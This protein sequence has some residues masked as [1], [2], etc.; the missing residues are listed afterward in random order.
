[1]GEIEMTAALLPAGHSI[2]G[3]RHG[4]ARLLVLMLL[5]VITFSGLVIM[6]V[7]GED[8]DQAP[9]V[10]KYSIKPPNL[11]P[12]SLAIINISIQQTGKTTVS[13]HSARGIGGYI[14]WKWTQNL[15]I[16]RVILEGN[17]LEVLSPDFDHIGDLG[18]TKTLCLYFT[19]RAPNK[20]G[21]FYPEIRIESNKKNTRY[22]FPVNVNTAVN[23]KKQAVIVMNTSLP[24]DVNPGDEIP[25]TVTLGNAGE[26]L[27]DAV[28][29]VI[30]N[31]SSAIAPKMTRTHYL[32][33]INPGE[34]KSVSL[35]LLSDRNANP[36]LIH[37]PVTLWYTQID[38]AVQS[39]TSF[40]DLI[41]KGTGEIGIMS[42][43]TNP[44]RIIENQPFDI[45]IRIGNTGTGT[46]KQVA[47]TIDLPVS[48]MQQTYIGKIEPGDD[49]SAIFLM[50]GGHVGS[51]LANAT[52]T[53]VDDVGVHTETREFS[54]R[55]I[56]DDS[57]TWTMIIVGLLVI[58]AGSLVYMYWYQ[59]WKT[60]EG[61]L[62]WVKKR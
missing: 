42:V 44:N 45:T 46:A 17:G 38:G 29:L 48:G 55:I 35:V 39:R 13:E 41:M 9:M 8:W 6:P 20:S 31:A 28:T 14:D 23:I 50:D 62:P 30:A 51:Y 40:I 33:L 60:D 1:M 52:I 5:V 47:A 61:V 15:Y 32:G 59:P 16:E 7:S 3:A 53:F 21:I 43:D 24:E 34:Q 36:G 11:A 25:V 57:S 22:P 2:T 58:I 27:A 26:T 10:V 12:D 4:S 18:P 19:I 56:H 49:A 37:V 54:L